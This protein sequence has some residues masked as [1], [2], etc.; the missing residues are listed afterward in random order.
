MAGARPIPPTP[1]TR[2][3]DALLVAGVRS[4]DEAA[5][6]ALVE[7]H[8][9]AMLRFARLYTPDAAL[10]E[11]VV[12]D[13]WMGALRGLARFEARSSVR[14]WLFGILLNRLRTRLKRECRCVPFSAL[15]DADAAPREPAVDPERF[16]GADHPR[17]PH[18]WS[19]APGSWG[20]SPEERLLAKEARE[21]IDRAVAALP[22]A[23][24]EVVTLRDVE[25]W[26]SAEVCELLRVS[27][28][29]QRVLLHRGRS[30]VRRALESYF[31][32]G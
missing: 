16:L 10:A 24:R 26:S 28:G 4:G 3:A 7:R 12:Q 6:A 1:T 23:Q 17:W 32:E 27:E 29:N 5:F 14:T 11:D 20:E 22:P 25:G 30:R 15:F 9:A 21:V 31:A 18:H 2:D 13:A 8:G 19:A